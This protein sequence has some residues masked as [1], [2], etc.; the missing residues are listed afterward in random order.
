MK[1]KRL[2]YLV[3]IVLFV[4]LI[5][6][7]NNVFGSNNKPLEKINEYNVYGFSTDFTKIVDDCKDSI[8]TIKA[9]NAISSGFVY[10]QKDDE[11]Y[12]V[13]TY[14]GINQA[15]SISV[16]FGTSYTCQASLVGYDIYTDLAVLM[17][18]TPYDIKPLII[19]DTQVLKQG[20]FVI[21]IGTPLSL[22]YKGSVELG[23]ISTN[24][25]MIE[26]NIN[27]DEKNYSY[28]LDVVQISA[29]LKAGYSGSPIIGMSGE[30]LGMNTM[31]LN[32]D[33]NFAITS[34]ELNILVNKIINGE[35]YDRLILGVKGTYIK[36]MPNYEKTNLGLTIDT[37]TG[38]YI[39][40]VKDDSL[41]QHYG[42][43]VG[44]IIVSINDTEI[45]NLNDYL[46]I[47]YNNN[48][49]E[50]ITVIRNGESMSLYLLSEND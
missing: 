41:A 9:D 21:S 28:Y 23:M 24:N 32:S 47:I 42:V 40:K 19:G 3:F 6:I 11:V 10:S 44:D 13:T 25:L 43:K 1:N 27:V 49:I 46:S 37:I 15:N 26:N 12:I 31:A 20:E 7:T 22:D 45:N 5:I 48:T 17:I 16:T 33:N 35:E 36:N 18:N 2:L 8:V 50:N 38:L 4:W 30:V 14:H 34:N 39:N 29:N